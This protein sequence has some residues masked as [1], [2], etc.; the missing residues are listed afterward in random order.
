[1]CWSSP[2]PVRELDAAWAMCYRG[3]SRK[4][5]K[6]C[7]SSHSKN[8]PQWHNQEL[9][10][11]SLFFI[12]HLGICGECWP[13][14][15]L[16]FLASIEGAKCICE[17]NQ[18]Y[19]FACEA[20]ASSCPCRHGVSFSSE[21]KC[22]P[23]LWSPCRLRDKTLFL[24]EVSFQGSLKMTAHWSISLKQLHSWSAL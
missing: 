22:R 20:L 6:S 5:K 15:Q 17:V 18:K 8:C 1:M 23:S 19:R 12:A 14:G 11:N 24:N 10:Q 7:F 16:I 13:P 21:S 9:L 4:A 3:L 2:H